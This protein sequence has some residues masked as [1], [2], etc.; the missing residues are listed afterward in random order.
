MNPR[1]HKLNLDLYNRAAD[2]TT[3][4]MAITYKVKSVLAHSYWMYIICACGRI[5]DVIDILQV[6]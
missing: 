6:N 5:T 1:K 4:N 3:I 2:G